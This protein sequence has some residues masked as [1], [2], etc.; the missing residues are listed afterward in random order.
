MAG[1]DGIKSGTLRW[2]RQSYL[3]TE[4][5]PQGAGQKLEDLKRIH[6]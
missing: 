3:W 2:E 1:E 6:N 5:E 4:K